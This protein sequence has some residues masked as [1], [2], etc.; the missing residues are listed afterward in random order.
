MLTS[1]LRFAPKHFN[2]K[3]LSGVD[4]NQSI[5]TRFR[6]SMKEFSGEFR[7]LRQWSLNFPRSHFGNFWVQILEFLVVR[8]FLSTSLWNLW[9]VLQ[10][11]NFRVQPRNF[12]WNFAAH[13]LG[14]CGYWAALKS[15]SWSFLWT[16]NSWAQ[17]L[18][19]LENLQL[20]VHTL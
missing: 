4:Q 5:S 1:Q 10:F 3:F 17:S 14:F 2:A 9:R 8:R 6:R 11:G 13:S 15:I 16:Y 19:F 12:Q 18:E 7:N 20:G